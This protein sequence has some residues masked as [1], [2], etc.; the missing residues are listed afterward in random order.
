MPHVTFYAHCLQRVS[1]CW[2]LGKNERHRTGRTMSPHGNVLAFIRGIIMKLHY[3]DNGYSAYK[4]FEFGCNGP[5]IRALYMKSKVNSVHYLGFHSKDFP[6]TPHHSLQ[7]YCLETMSVWLA[8][9]INERQVLYVTYI[10]DRGTE[11]RCYSFLFI[12]IRVQ[13]CCVIN[14]HSCTFSM[15]V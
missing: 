7:L 2:L 3:Y 11:L 9:A 6:E 14:F 8:S 10:H 1:V 12:S 4:R 5:I 15:H 13:L